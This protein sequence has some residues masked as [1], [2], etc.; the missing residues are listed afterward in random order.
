MIVRAYEPKDFAQISHWAKT[1]WDTDYSEDQFPKTGFIVDDVAAFFMYTTDS[2]VCFL[3]N[4]VS[5][6]EAC[7]VTRDR[8]I[9]LLILKAFDHARAHGFKVAYAVTDNPKVIV[10]A[11]IHNCTF[12][13]KQTLITKN[14]TTHQ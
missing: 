4:M 8:A 9:E 13:P 6:R 14:L 7:P 3:E 12:K 10:R 1:H 2:T 5:N 11:S